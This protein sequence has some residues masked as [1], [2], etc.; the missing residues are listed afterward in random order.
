[1]RAAAALTGVVGGLCWVGTRWVDPLIWGGAV[2]LGLAV[3]VAGAALVSRSATWLRAIAAVGFAA[4]AGSVVQLLRDQADDDLVLTAVG[5]VAIA[6]GV[7]VLSRRPVH[8][9]AHTR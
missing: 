9:G 1:M 5:A 4:L 3:L 7:V 2:L 8:H 6:V